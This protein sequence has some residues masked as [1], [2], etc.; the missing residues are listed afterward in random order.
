MRLSSHVRVDIFDHVKK[1]I[2]EHHVVV[3]LKDI[4]EILV[5]LIGGH[6]QRSSL[7]QLGTQFVHFVRW[8]SCGGILE[9]PPPHM[10]RI[11][12]PVVGAGVVPFIPPGVIPHRLHH[13][14]RGADDLIHV[15][16]VIAN[17]PLAPQV[18]PP[19]GEEYEC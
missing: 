19:I 7:R 5:P 14:R 10:H 17:E 9:I 16:Q 6:V 13:P 4:E 15:T 12:Y 11:V 1:V 8:Q 3:L 18:L 2:Q